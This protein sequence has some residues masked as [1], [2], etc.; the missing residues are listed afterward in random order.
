V[1]PNR[2]II[3]CY[4][5]IA[6]VQQY[7][8]KYFNHTATLSPHHIYNTLE[9]WWYSPLCH[10]LLKD[11]HK[12]CSVYRLPFPSIVSSLTSSYQ[13][14]LVTEGVVAAVTVRQYVFL[15]I[16]I[17]TVGV[18]WRRPRV[19]VAA[20]GIATIIT[21]AAVGIATIITVATVCKCLVSEQRYHR[22]DTYGTKY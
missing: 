9:R 2:K 4:K 13:S 20:V 5:N 15:V 7:R 21:V 19:I 11:D 18:G 16:C 3:E 6:S 17:A 22:Y 8:R 1:E 10:A 14:R 12:L